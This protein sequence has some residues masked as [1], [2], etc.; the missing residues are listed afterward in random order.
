MST[1]ATAVCRVLRLGRAWRRALLV[2]MVAPCAALSAMRAAAQ[3]RYYSAP[4]TVYAHL[5]RHAAPPLDAALGL[6]VCVGNEW[7]R[8]PS[9]FFLPPRA[10]LAFVRDGFRG[11]LPAHFSAAWPEGSR[12]RH[13]HFNDLNREAFDKG[14]DLLVFPQGTRSIRLSRG[15]IGL[16][17]TALHLKKTIVPVGC[18]GSDKV[19]TGNL[20]VGSGGHITYRIGEPLRYEEMSEF[21]I[22]EEFEPFTAEAENK[23]REKFQGYVD[24]VMERINGLL[25]PQYQFAEDLSSDGVAGSRRFL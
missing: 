2:A 25:E 10:H 4:L 7:Y 15:R 6:R 23:H 19:Y 9:S 11:Q 18:N 17:Q 20:P 14:L 21:H 3:V 5:A 22:D 8:Y 13:A 12:V 24:V 16:S 1:A